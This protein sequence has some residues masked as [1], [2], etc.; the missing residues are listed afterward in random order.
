LVSRHHQHFPSSTDHAHPLSPE[1]F[2]PSSWS[3][4][5]SPLSMDYSAP[6]SWLPKYSPPSPPSSLSTDHCP[7]SIDYSP[8]TRWSTDLPPPSPLPST[9]GWSQGH[10]NLRMATLHRAQSRQMPSMSV[11]LTLN[12][13]RTVHSSYSLSVA[14][15]RLQ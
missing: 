4:G 6:N 12:S 10:T 3:I 15:M 11:L 8:P 5:H 13:D 9:P 7:M 2:Q 14:H 1:Y